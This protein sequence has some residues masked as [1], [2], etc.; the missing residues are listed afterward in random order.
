[1]DVTTAQCVVQHLQIGN[2]PVS[3]RMVRQ[4]LGSGL[5]TTI[6]CHWRTYVTASRPGG[7]TGGDMGRLSS[8]KAVET[9]KRG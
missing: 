8:G 1:M 4:L 3:F 7:G 2:R 5:F 6:A 9:K